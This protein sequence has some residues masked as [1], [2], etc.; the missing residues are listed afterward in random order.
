MAYTLH[1]EL[2][3]ATLERAFHT[4][5]TKAAA[6]R[7]AKR[8]AKSPAFMV[9]RIVVVNTKTELSVATFECPQEAEQ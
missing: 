9:A 3:D 8:L 4:L 7:V 5:P 1:N 2:T 6:L